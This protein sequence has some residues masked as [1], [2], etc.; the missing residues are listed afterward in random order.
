MTLETQPTHDREI[1][2]LGPWFHNLHLPDGRRTAPEHPLGDFPA[3]KWRQLEQALPRDLHGWTALDVG[4]NAGFYSFELARRGAK[5]LGVD[6][7]E[8]YLRQARWARAQL[9]LDDRVELRRMQVYDLLSL[10]ERF[11][12]VLF[13]GVLYHLRY[14][15]LALDAVAR[16][17]R[18]LVAVQT[19]TT[20]DSSP[21]DPPTDLS[22]DERE[23]LRDAGWPALAFVE[24]SLAG[25]PTNWWVP[26]EACAEAMLRSAGLQIVARPG[27]ELWVCRPEVAR[28]DPEDYVA[29]WSA[30]SG[31]RRRPATAD[32]LL[33]RARRQLRRLT[34][35]AAL[36]A[37]RQGALLV[38]LRAGDERARDGVVPGSVHIPRTVLE[39]RFDP[40]SPS[41]DPRVCDRERLVVLLCAHGY[42]SSLAAASLQELGYT[43][44]TDVDGGF[45]AW[46]AAGLPVLET[47]GPDEPEERCL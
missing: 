1:A 7:D 16:R 47:P 31:V 17:A 28:A 41:R 13:L 10:R 43:R 18:R 3:F 34:P 46:R 21:V 33:E 37:Q 29:V 14:P 23:R 30:V 32:E 20:P 4:C 24:R 22:L 39:W 8:R 2:A 5:V 19:L 45:E 25:D 35:A 36:A 12:L 9:G 15:L 26:N 6:A 44:A 38:D 40:T 11:D 27:H 42:S